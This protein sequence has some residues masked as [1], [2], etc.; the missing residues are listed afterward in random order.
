M[1]TMLLLIVEQ[2]MG[3]DV[4]HDDKF[5]GKD[6]A[7][8]WVLAFAMHPFKVSLVYCSTDVVIDGIAIE[9]ACI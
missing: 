2:A 6:G 1:R 7:V 5:P 8:S 3:L 9:A 4:A